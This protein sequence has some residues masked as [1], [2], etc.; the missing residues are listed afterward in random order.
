MPRI[1]RAWLR[2]LR[3][4]MVLN[5]FVPK[6]WQTLDKIERKKKHRANGKNR[7]S[8]PNDSMPISIQP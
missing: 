1:F 6:P 7:Y 5:F 3:G 8:D 4:R 2:S